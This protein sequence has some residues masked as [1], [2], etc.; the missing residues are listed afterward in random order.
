MASPPGRVRAPAFAS[1][2]VAAYPGPILGHRPQSPSTRSSDGS[3][4]AAV[5]RRFDPVRM[6]LRSARTSVAVKSIGDSTAPCG[7][8]S[9]E[10]HV[11]GL[12]TRRQ[13]VASSAVKH[14]GL[15]GR[16]VDREP[17][18][19]VVAHGPPT[20]HRQGPVVGTGTGSIYRAVDV[21]GERDPTTRWRKGRACSPEDDTVGA[22][23][24][25]RMNPFAHGRACGHA[26]T[27]APAAGID[28]R[29]PCKVARMRAI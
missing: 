16:P 29:G 5:S 4:M 17:H 19:C 1:V 25:V 15:G 24:L 2:S 8:R 26:V 23:F 22:V 28:A 18:A 13:S 10:R 7:I 11:L 9:A 3:T 12:P 27:T 6:N 21:Q 14:H 20:R